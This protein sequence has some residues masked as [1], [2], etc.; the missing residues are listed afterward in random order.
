MADF[1]GVQ[2][3]SVTRWMYGTRSLPD[4]EHFIKLMCY[5]DAV[6]YKVIELERMPKARRNF[7]ELIGF[8]ILSIEQAAELLGYASVSTL[9]QVLRGN[10]GA[11]ED[12][13]Q[14][15][16]NAWK[17]KREELERSKEKARELYCLGDETE[18]SQKAESVKPSRQQALPVR[19]S[20]II[21][22][23]EGLLALLEDKPLEKLSKDDLAVVLRLSA[24]LS[25]LSSQLIMSDQQKRGD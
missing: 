14:K 6:G 17:E 19:H 16:W 22:I 11:S 4:G 5:L 7:L 15:M 9:F 18:I 13:D 20:A 23:M 1:C 21:S 24:H 3:D 12:K 25:A 10:Q 8:S 2:I